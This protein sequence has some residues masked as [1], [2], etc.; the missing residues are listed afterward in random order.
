MCFRK[1][2]CKTIGIIS[3]LD[4]DVYDNGL[5]KFLITDWIYPLINH[6][7]YDGELTVSEMKKVIPRLEWVFD[8]WRVESNPSA[9]Y[10]LIT[11]EQ[12]V[13]DMKIASK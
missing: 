13:N 5:Y 8:Q 3:S 12:L 6:S 9:E 2:I 10:D 11:G 7:D 1:R 4:G